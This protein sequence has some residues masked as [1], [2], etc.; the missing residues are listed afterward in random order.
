MTFI[1]LSRTLLKQQFPFH[2]IPIRQ[3]TVFTPQYNKSNEKTDKSLDSDSKANEEDDDMRKRL[4]RILNDVSQQNKVIEETIRKEKEKGKEL[5]ESLK[6]KESEHTHKLQINKPQ[7]SM[8]S[9]SEELSKDKSEAFSYMDIFN[10]KHIVDT[11]KQSENVKALQQ[12]LT[13]FYENRKKNQ[14]EFNES[15]S[16]KMNHNVKELK[17]SISI[18]SKVVNEITGY[19]KVIK[20]KDIIV[21]NEAKLKEL[22][23]G[24]HQAKIE[25][26]KAL[27][28]RSSSQKEV[29]EL[30]ERKNSWNPLDLDRFT[31]IYMN[32][33]DLDKTVRETSSNLKKL[34]DSQESTHDALIRSIMNRYHEE[35]V[36]SDKI[37]QFSTWGTI[38]IMCINLLLVFLVQFV[39][40]PFK[41]WRLVNSFEGKVKELFHN[42]EKL[43]SDIQ[44]LKEQL[45]KINSDLKREELTTQFKNDI[46]EIIESEQSK[47]LVQSS[48]EIDGPICLH[49][50]PPFRIIKNGRL[51]TETL[52]IY[53]QYYF[54]IFKHW[55]MLAGQYV[56][57]VA[58]TNTVPL[59]T[60]VGE[61]QKTI[62]GSITAGV[63][64][65]ILLGHNL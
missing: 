36:W 7:Q 10:I 9:D 26:E 6:S 24:I 63:L 49:E 51:D 54:N 50:L 43:G 30:L 29:N 64:T 16:K 11:V 40:E 14:Q 25:H 41:R 12:E 52:Q 5:E 32:T 33:H 8:P 28:L 46:P 60:T 39:F 37:R 23:L 21:E 31:K 45:Q 44:E 27:E 57:P 15:F 55:I 1:R 59:H 18:A 34:E 53:A 35:Q 13:T 20:L 61:Y 56:A 42:N 65:G 58:W 3:F 38:I 2:N 19:N 17:N 62:I 48:N 47:E 22:K 4:S